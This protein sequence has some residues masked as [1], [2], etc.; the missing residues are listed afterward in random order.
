M[1]SKPHAL[2]VSHAS[3]RPDAEEQD[4]LRAQGVSAN[5]KAIFTIEFTS[6]RLYRLLQCLEDRAVR[7]EHYHEVEELVE[8]AIYIRNQAKEQ[9][10]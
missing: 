7:A 4:R 8:M 1:S 6:K 2:H 5:R 9:G 3:E 10:W